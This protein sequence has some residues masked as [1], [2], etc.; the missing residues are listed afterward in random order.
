MAPFTR[1]LATAA[2]KYGIIIT[3][4]GG[5]VAFYAEDPVTSSSNPYTSPDGFFGGKYPNQLLQQFPWSELQVVQAPL[6]SR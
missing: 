1:M 5:A 3:D 2:Q 4:M 6:S